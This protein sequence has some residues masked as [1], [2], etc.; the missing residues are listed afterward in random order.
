MH[1]T[2]F[3]PSGYTLARAHSL[4][5]TKCTDDTEPYS[6]ETVSVL[7]LAGG[8]PCTCSTYF[9]IPPVYGKV[10]MI[11]AKRTEVSL[12]DIPNQPTNRRN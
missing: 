6:N 2:P 8:G 4:S 9:Q 5:K 7:R 10:G 12:H 3:S 11:C 1:F